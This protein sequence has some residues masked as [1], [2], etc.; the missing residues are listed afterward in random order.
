MEFLFTTAAVLAFFACIFVL[1]AYRAKKAEKE[2]IE[3]IRSNYLTLSQK[4]YSADRFA[5][6]DRYLQTHQNDS[7]IDEITWNDCGMDDL[8]K[9][10][11]YTLSAIGEEYLYYQLHTLKQDEAELEHLEELV[12]SIGANTETRTKLQFLF[13]Q[14]GYMGK[15]SIYDYIDNLDYLGERSN[16]K[17]FLTLLMYP[18]AVGLMFIHFS[19]GIA[20]VVGVMLYH[21]MTYFKEKGEIEPYIISFAYIQKMTVCSDA[22]VKAC[23]NIFRRETELLKKIT[24]TIRPMNFASFLVMDSEANHR[25]SGDIIGVIIDYFKMIFHLDLIK[26][27]SMYHLVESHT[28]EIDRMITTLGY[29]ENVINTWIF[30]QSLTNGWCVPSFSEERGVQMEEG[31]HPMLETPVK[32]SIATEKNVLLTGSNASGKSTFLKTVAINAILA[33]TIHTCAA[34]SFVLPFM[35]VYSSMTLKDDIQGG[36]SYYIV[37]IKALKRILD[38]AAERNEFVLCFVDEVLRGTNTVERIAASSQILA[39]LPD[40]AVCFAATHD[41]ELTDLLAHCY[42]NYHFEEDIHNGDIHFNYKLLEGKATTRN[43]IKLLELL[44]YDE[45]MIER[46]TQRAEHFV[47]TGAWE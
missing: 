33:Q 41:I 25:A 42:D 40:N 7:Q 34:D 11:N 22:V 43:A 2:Y 35:L 36:D 8:F 31:Y 4:E 15:Y 20:A 45:A 16:K 21:M 1:E 29:M 38:V 44:G 9:R 27:N 19:L 46:A 13:H 6:L 24:A 32:N 17:H 26:F 18:A 3:R 23:P 10:M 39:G 37:E 14:L 12:Q 30:R 5:K 47:K 28:E